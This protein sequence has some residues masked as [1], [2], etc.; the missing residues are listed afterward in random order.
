MVKI[1][2]LLFLFIASFPFFIKEVR[3]ENVKIQKNNETSQKYELDK[4]DAITSDR[5]D[6]I[7]MM[8]SK[9]PGLQATLKRYAFQLKEKA[10]PTLIKVMKTSKYPIQNRWHA[11]MLLARI[12]GSKSSPF[13]AKF[14]DHPHWMMRLA[15]LKALLGLK[16]SNYTGIY[17]KALR[18]P[19]LIVRVQ[20]LDNISKLKI[21]KL[22]SHVWEMMYDQSN[23]TGEQGSRKRTSIIKSIIRTLGDVKYQNA[24]GPFAKLI[25][26]PKY[27]D[28]IDDLDYSLEKITG[29][30]S[31]DALNQRR[32]F[33]SNLSSNNNKI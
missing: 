22:S 31:P 33:W 23:Y 5:L 30:V 18:D 17:A 19:S 16:Q 21:T 14:S 3:S 6:Q 13:I 32:K 7:F 9:T 24:K 12:V 1:S 29:K 26:K 2:F 10:V 4:I 20:A 27:I 11:T 8:D 15:S 25:L 28:L